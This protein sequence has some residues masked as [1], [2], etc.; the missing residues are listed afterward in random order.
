LELINKV[1]YSFL[2]KLLIRLPVL[3][4]SIIF[5]Y[6]FVSTCCAEKFI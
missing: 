1:P 6:V 3:Y 2:I 5:G 4:L